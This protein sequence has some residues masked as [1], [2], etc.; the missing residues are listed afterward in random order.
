MQ[1]WRHKFEGGGGSMHWK[2]GWGVNKVSPPSP[3]P[4]FAPP[5]AICTEAEFSDI[6]TGCYTCDKNISR[7]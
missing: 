6:S 5:L 3:T 1:G 7:G 2:V 4:M